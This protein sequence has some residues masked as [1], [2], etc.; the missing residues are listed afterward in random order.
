MKITVVHRY[1]QNNWFLWQAGCTK[2]P[3][4]YWDLQ[5]I[6]LG[7][8]KALWSR[9]IADVL[10]NTTHMLPP[11]GKSEIMWFCLNPFLS[12]LC[13]HQHT[14]SPM[15]DFLNCNHILCFLWN[16]QA[17]C[18]NSVWFWAISLWIGAYRS[19]LLL[20]VLWG[21]WWGVQ[22]HQHCLRLTRCMQNYFL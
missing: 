9:L 19:H 20:F 2:K 5:G 6:A 15:Q 17:I 3:P 18:H 1:G 4:S 21:R 14:S 8:H 11:P 13:T 22:D 10:P 16:V 7:H 12:P